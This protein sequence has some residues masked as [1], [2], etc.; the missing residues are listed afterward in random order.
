MSILINDAG[1]QFARFRTVIL[2]VALGGLILFTPGCLPPQPGLAV[3]VNARSLD[4]DKV[5]A[6]LVS[7]LTETK[8]GIEFVVD[9]GHFAAEAS[10]H[11][12]AIWASYGSR[13]WLTVVAVLNNWPNLTVWAS[14]DREDCELIVRLRHTKEI[15]GAE[16]E[17]SD[18][19]KEYARGLLKLLEGRYGANWVKGKWVG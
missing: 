17:L 19:E 10:L 6:D 14:V 7:L 16:K 18:G 12:P 2:G 15:F 5:R 4:C 8:G 9:E 3:R 1:F 13:R 11:D